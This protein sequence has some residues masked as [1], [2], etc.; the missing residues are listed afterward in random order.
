MELAKLIAERRG[1]TYNEQYRDRTSQC[2]Y[3]MKLAGLV[4]CEDGCGLLS[5]TTFNK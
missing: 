2:L 4:R 1:E 3:R 5:V